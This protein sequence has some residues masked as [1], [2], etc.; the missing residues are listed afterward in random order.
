MLLL[1][2]AHYHMLAFF[3]SLIGLVWVWQE[4]PFPLWGMC[5]CFVHGGMVSG[6][7]VDGN[8]RLD[9]HPGSVA[10]HDHPDLVETRAGRHHHHHHH[11]V[12]LCL[13]AL[14]SGGRLCHI[15]VLD[16]IIT[17]LSLFVAGA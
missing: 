16:V 13:L 12:V 5:F 10:G 6:R 14:V 3:A 2:C 11:H 1:C 8:A 7:Y 15:V 17:M 4:D 9:D